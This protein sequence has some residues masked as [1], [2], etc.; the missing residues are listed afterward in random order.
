MIVPFVYEINIV[1]FVFSSTDSILKKP[2]FLA[3]YSKWLVPLSEPQLS[4]SLLDF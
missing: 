4:Q 2:H 1:A 3:F